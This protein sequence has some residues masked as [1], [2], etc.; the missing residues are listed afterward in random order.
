MTAEE[1]A[2]DGATELL[3]RDAAV[4]IVLDSREATLSN[5]PAESVTLDSIAGRTLATDIV[6]ESDLPPHDYATMD[7]YAVDATEP[8][9]LTV[10]GEETFPEDD[11]AELDTGTAVPIAT[12]APLPS[13]ANAVL[14]REA[15]T[16]DGAE[17]TGTALT[18]GTDVYE[19][20]SNAERGDVLFT[21]GERLSPKDS[22]YLC[23]LGYDAVPVRERLSTAV[24]ATGTEIHEGRSADL[25]SDMLAGFVDRWGHTAT[26]EGAVPDRYDQIADRLTELTREYDVVLTTGGTSVGHRDHV[27]RALSEIGTVCL[28]TVR[29]R[30]GKP[31]AV[32]ETP[33]AVVFAIPGKPVGAYVISALVVRPFFTGERA[34][35]TREATFATALELGPEG[36]DY[37]IPVTLDDGTA[38]PL[39]HAESPLSVYGSTFDPSVLAASTRAT[40]ADGFVRTRTA[41]SAGETVAVVPHTVFD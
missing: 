39:G 4:D 30:P 34:L 32:A 28:N 23:D 8:Y 3:W 35:P 41:L 27:V 16:V 33:D 5:Q 37:V 19:Q 12:G 24:L 11:P 22:V 13:G 36:F 20:G 38:T 2:T 1:R 9:P 10:R 7:G 29:I 21:A 31:I 40:R 18:P 6:A 15:A 25:D 17:L 14:K 26:Y